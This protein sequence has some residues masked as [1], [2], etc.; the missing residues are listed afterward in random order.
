MLMKMGP[1]AIWLVP[2]SYVNPRVA[3][4]PFLRKMST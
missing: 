1:V 2:P 3:V 4:V